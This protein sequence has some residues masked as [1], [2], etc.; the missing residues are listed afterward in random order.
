MAVPLLLMAL[1]IFA[2]L[3][4]TLHFGVSV[5]RTD[6]WTIVPLV[7]AFHAGQL[8]LGMLWSQHNENRMLVPNLIQ[9]L[10]ASATHFDTRAPMDLGAGLL[11][12]SFAVLVA[13]YR[14]MGRWAYW[15]MVPIALLLFSWVQVWN[16]L[17]GFQMAWY[18]VLLCLTVMIAG[19]AHPSR[20]GYALAVAAAVIASY[21]SLQGLFLWPCGLVML[22]GEPPGRRR[23]AVWLG[24]GTL[25]TLV[26][27]YHYNFSDSAS[28]SLTFVLVH[29]VV[30]AKYLLITIGTVMP[31]LRSGA[32]AAS[33]Q[34]SLAPTALAGA[35]ILG[36]ALVALV[37][38]VLM[39]GRDRYL[40]GS[41]A[42]IIFGLLFDLAVDV[43]R[44]FA[45]AGQ[46]FVLWRYPTYNLALL[47]GVWLVAV[48]LWQRLAP[49]RPP[50]LVLAVAGLSAVLALQ[51]GLSYHFG[52]QEGAATASQSLTAR[53]VLANFRTAPAGL[54][55][56]YLF[57]E[58]PEI[59]AWAPILVRLHDSVFDGAAAA[60]Y[61]RIGIVPGGQLGR[62]LPVPPYLRPDL[63]RGST[64]ARAWGV[65]STIY[66]DS[67]TLRRAYPGA[68]PGFAQALLTWA[69]GPA[70]QEP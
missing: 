65:L 66:D 42:L 51:A 39:G 7:G 31:G 9:V 30:A 35:V 49:A 60:A 4:F 44:A 8:T 53:D 5:V 19:L 52:A 56:R 38:V 13:F 25:A 24:T 47:V 28:P 15:A 36:L 43:G 64:S 20:I 32:T 61:G 69:A 26:Y 46:P 12:L 1:P 33:P 37:V 2:Y 3:W 70:Q 21:S 54:Q 18:L 57:L 55:S 6:E 17:F 14:G 11:V 16:A 59:Q 41:A 62:L 40:R 58:W 45:G 50:Q 67:P 63:A 68:Q 34:G 27:L 23:Q 29:P 10:L 48:R 22:R